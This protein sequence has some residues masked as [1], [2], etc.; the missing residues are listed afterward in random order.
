MDRNIL[1]WGCY[2]N[3][4]K[5]TRVRRGKIVVIPEEWRGKEPQY[6]GVLQERYEKRTMRRAERRSEK[7]KAR[8]EAYE[9]YID[10]IDNLL[11][12]GV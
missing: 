3:Y 9:Q 5:K 12:E 2:D 4:P 7:L 1:P 10:E 6:P 8:R 11:E